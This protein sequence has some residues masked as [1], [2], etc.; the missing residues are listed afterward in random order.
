MIP[1]LVALV[2][3]RLVILNRGRREDRFGGQRQCVRVLSTL[4]MR[5]IL[6]KGE[7]GDMAQKRGWGE[8]TEI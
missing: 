6:I 8:V 7:R 1:R 3:R 2:T 4:I 5:R